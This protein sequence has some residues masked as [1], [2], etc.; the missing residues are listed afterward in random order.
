MFM[1]HLVRGRYIQVEST[2][3][4]VQVLRFIPPGM[5]CD[6]YAPWSRRGI[7]ATVIHQWESC[8]WMYK[9]LLMLR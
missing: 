8:K 7:W 4:V 5:D 2:N 1:T 6:P 9:P 3:Y